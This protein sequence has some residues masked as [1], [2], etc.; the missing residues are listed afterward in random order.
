MDLFYIVIFLSGVAVG[1]AT[2]TFWAKHNASRIRDKGTLE[3]NQLILELRSQKESFQL[4]LVQA[5]VRLTEERRHMEEKLTF[6]A[7]ARDQLKTEFLNLANQ[8]LEEKSRVFSQENKESLLNILTPLRDDLAGFKKKVEDV[9]DKESQGRA[10]LVNE[11]T[12]L[13]DLNQRI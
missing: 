7:N 8:I 11:V 5:E 4:S 12:K 6:V 1:A 3:Q 10:A 13:R 2:G 9:Y